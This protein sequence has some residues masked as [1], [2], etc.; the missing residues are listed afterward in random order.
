MNSFPTVS[1][2]QDSVVNDFC[3]LVTRILSTKDT[4]SVSLS[5]GSTPK[6]IYEMLADR[7][8]PW[9]QIHFFWGD[10]R[11]VPHDHDDSNAKMV[12]TAL[13]D[14]I[15]IPPANVHRVPVDVD[16]PASAAKA[17]ETTLRE[18][19]AGQAFP[20]WDLN[21]LGMGDDAH[22]ASLFPG[23][24]AID[25]TDRWYVE[26]WVEKLD[27]FRYTLTAP[28][29]NSASQKW[30]MVSGENKRAALASVSSDQIAPS[31]YPSQLITNPKWYVTADA[32]P[33]A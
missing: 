29:I 8:L 17:Y 25:Q 28:A 19:F 22:T 9:S 3:D 20:A 26:N 33:Q 14:R 5:G 23:T 30:F 21:L 1:D 31:E 16:N 4:F 27:T 24:S 7:D 10:E 6:R 15:S 18:H 11:N 12:S 32:M 13:L 2:L